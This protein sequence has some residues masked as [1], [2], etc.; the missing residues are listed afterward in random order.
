MRTL[1][2]VLF[3]TLGPIV[4]GRCHP[5]V[6]PQDASFPCIRY[7]TASTR[8][9][10]SLCGNSGLVRSSVQIDIYAQN[11]SEVRSLRESVLAAMLAFPAPF[12]TLL[13]MEQDA[14]ESDVK[15]FRRMMQFSIA[16]QEGA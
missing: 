10:D 12:A 15:L 1:E 2:T 8:M 3:T 5:V 14:F 13:T 11:F 9:E 4:S 16:E 7:A 6:I